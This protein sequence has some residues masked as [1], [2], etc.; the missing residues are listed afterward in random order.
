M[1]SCGFAI[2]FWCKFFE[3][4]GLAA[5]F[6]LRV[7]AR[8]KRN[9]SFISHVVMK[10]D[11]C[12]SQVRVFPISCELWDKRSNRIFLGHESSFGDVW[13]L[14]RFYVFLWLCFLAFL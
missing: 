6:D 1:W 3:V 4:V 10:R 12:G 11:L 8:S 9:F 5:L 2:V 14:V 7:V 13:S